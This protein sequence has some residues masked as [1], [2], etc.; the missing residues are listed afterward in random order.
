MSMGGHKEGNL[1]GLGFL[2]TYH[3]QKTAVSSI[4]SKKLFQNSQTSKYDPTDKMMDGVF[5][6]GYLSGIGVCYNPKNY[7]YWLGNFVDKDQVDVLKKGTGWP[8]NSIKDYRME[9]H[10]RSPNFVS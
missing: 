6:K 3:D 1:H 7:E 2:L 10:L 5:D 4:K 8:E 9:F